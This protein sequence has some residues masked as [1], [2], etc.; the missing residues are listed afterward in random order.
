MKKKKWSCILLVLA[1]VLALTACQQGTE[2][3]ST[4]QKTT[5]PKKVTE[6]KKV[7]DPKQLYT[8]AFQKTLDAKT[9]DCSI[10]ADINVDTSNL[11]GE[12]KE[13]ADVI[14]NAKLTVDIKANEETKQSELV[15]KG[16]FS[17]RNLTMDF[18]VPVYMDEDKQRGYIKLDSMLKNFGIFLGTSQNHLESV[19]DK[20]LEFP[21]EDDQSFTSYTEEK[22]KQKSRES[23]NKMTGDLPQNKFKKEELTSKEKQQG[24]TQKVTLSLSDKEMKAAFIKLID[25]MGKAM[26]DPIS[27]SELSE[28]EDML[29]KITVKKLKMTGTIDDKETFRNYDAAI[30]VK[31]QH[32]DFSGDIGLRL[33]TSYKHIN[34]DVT[35][36]DKPKKDQIVSED[37][38]EKILTIAP[39]KI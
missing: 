9:Y 39:Q 32:S 4:K 5:E 14:N 31:V 20:Y 17:Y 1:F 16:K 33:S 7:I 34:E 11:Q 15:F 28:M 8:T 27:K 13:F 22:I 6:Q 36:M 38:F 24:A 12:Y 30:L 23:L 25:V 10:D 37:E 26:N 18:N 3:K 21:L 2:Q 19:K 35:L 29:K